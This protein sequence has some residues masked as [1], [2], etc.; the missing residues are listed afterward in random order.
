MISKNKNI[1]VAWKWKSCYLLTCSDFMFVAV[2]HCH[3]KTK[4][5]ITFCCKFRKYFARAP[6]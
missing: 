5:W 3:C 6:F 4:H 2:W 1:H